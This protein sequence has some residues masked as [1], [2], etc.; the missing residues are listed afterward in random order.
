MF[1]VPL[2]NYYD[3]T[4]TSLGWALCPLYSGASL[5]LF[6]ELGPHLNY[7]GSTENVPH[8]ICIAGSQNC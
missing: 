7:I 8:L 6:L 4:V 1:F 5:R 3:L 2:Y